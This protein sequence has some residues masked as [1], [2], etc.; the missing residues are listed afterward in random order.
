MNDVNRKS[1]FSITLGPLLLVPA[2]GMVGSV[3]SIMNLSNFS[4]FTGMTALYLMYGAIGLMFA[5]PGTIIFGLPSMLALRA[6]NKFN[7]PML[8]AVS[9]IPATIIFGL[10]MPTLGGWLFYGYSSAAVAVGCWYAF[11]W[12]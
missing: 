10:V 1:L 4:D 3:I 6:Y 8:I 5:Y 12:A 9:L 2:L 7:L 11:K